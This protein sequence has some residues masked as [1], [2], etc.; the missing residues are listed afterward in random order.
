MFSEFITEH[1]KAIKPQN[2]GPLLMKSSQS[3]FN[4][5]LQGSFSARSYLI[6]TV[7]FSTLYGCFFYQ[8]KEQKRNG[9]VKFVLSNFFHL[10]IWNAML[11][12][13]MRIKSPFHVKFVAKH[14]LKNVTE[15]LILGKC[16]ALQCKFVI[17]HSFFVFSPLC[18]NFL[19]ELE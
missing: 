15:I 17:F 10:Q 3:N 18:F 7:L 1:V 2:W 14:S 6:T 13:R 4:L 11:I 19:L 9:S 12:Q 16:I 5:R 8:K